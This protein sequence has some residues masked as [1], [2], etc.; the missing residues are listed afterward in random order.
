MTNRDEDEDE[1]IADTEP[2]PRRNWPVT[3]KELKDTQGTMS[4]GHVL[5]GDKAHVFNGHWKHEGF[6]DI[7]WA[8]V[9]EDCA[10]ASGHD[11][12]KVEFD[13]VLV[14]GSGPMHK[15]N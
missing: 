1:D 10:Q 14:F 13:S 5:P 6:D 2:P 7:F 12:A 4:C 8:A 9:C 3:N 15:D 11:L